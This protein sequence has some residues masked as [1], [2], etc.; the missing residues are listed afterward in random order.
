MFALKEAAILDRYVQTEDERLDIPERL[1]R[2][3]G[4]F[5]GLTRLC[6]AVIESGQQLVFRPGNIDDTFRSPDYT[7]GTN[8]GGRFNNW[9]V[10]TSTLS[11]FTGYLVGFPRIRIANDRYVDCLHM[12]GDSTEPRTETYAIP[13]ASVSGLL[14]YS[15]LRTRLDIEIDE[16]QSGKPPRY[17]I[18]VNLRDKRTQEELYRDA[19]ERDIDRLIAEIDEPAAIVYGDFHELE[20]TRRVA[21]IEDEVCLHLLDD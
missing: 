18:L 11:L 5:M 13:L 6:E 20:S 21:E 12:W 1:G 9:S 7:D 10:E 14:I 15:S 4:T 3:I 16:Q 8:I 2:S 19:E 17:E